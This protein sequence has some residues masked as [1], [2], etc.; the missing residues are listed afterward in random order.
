MDWVPSNVVDALAESH[1]LG[2][3]LHIA[4][5]PAL[6]VW[7][8]VNDIPIQIESVDEAGAVYQGGGRL[9]GVP[10]LETLVNG[11]ADSV[12]FAMSGVDPSSGAKVLESIPPVRGADVFVGITTLDDYY[13]PMSQIVP[14]WCGTASHPTESSPTVMGAENR[15]LTLGLVVAAGSETRSRPARSLWSSAHQKAISATDRFCDNTS[16]IARG[17]QPA[18]PA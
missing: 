11:T 13:Q 7:L 6:R 17:V 2:I 10:T 1:Q 14:L 12:E 9:I 4:T 5:V 18:W 16:R 3:F 8:G 15:S